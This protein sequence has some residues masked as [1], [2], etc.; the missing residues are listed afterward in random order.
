MTTLEISELT[1]LK[2]ASKRDNF[3]RF[4]KF[5]KSNSVSEETKV[6]LGDME[7]YLAADPSRVEV[8]WPGFE[9]W[10]HL[11]RHKSM[12]KT[13]ADGYKKII[14]R[15]SAPSTAPINDQ[16]VLDHFTDLHYSAKILDVVHSVIENGKGSLN[17]VDKIMAEYMLEKGNADRGRAKYLKSSFGESVAAVYRPD[18]LEWPIAAL[19]KGVGPINPGDFIILAARPECFSD[20]TE[21]LTVDG[22]VAGADLSVSHQVACV[23]DYGFSHFLHPFSVKQLP[24]DEELWHFYNDKGSVDLLVTADHRMTHRV[25]GAATLKETLASEMKWNYNKDYVVAAP[26]PAGEVELTPYERVQIAFQADGSYGNPAST[27]VRAGGISYKFSLKKAR[28][29]ERLKMLCDMAGIRYTTSAAKRGQTYFHVVANGLSKEFDWVNLE[30]MSQAKAKQFIDEVA[31]W[32]STRRSETRIKFDTTNKAVADKVQAVAVL[33]GYR[34]Y[35]SR[36]EDNRKETFND[37][38]SLTILCDKDFVSGGTIKSKLV[39]YKGNVTA[40]QVPTGRVLVRRNGKVA[41]SGNCGKTSLALFFAQHWLKQTTGNLLIVNN[42]ERGAKIK[43]RFAQ[44]TLAMMRTDLE[45]MKPEEVDDAMNTAIGSTDRVVLLESD[46]VSVSDVER[47][48]AEIQPKFIIFNVLDKVT[49]FEEAKGNDVARLRRLFQWGRALAARGI[50]VVALAQAGEEA[51]GVQWITQN[52]IYGS[53]TGA[54]GEAD[55]MLTMG[56]KNE[57]GSASKRFI[58]TPKN[59]LPGG[60]GSDPRER[61]GYHIVEFDQETGQFDG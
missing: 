39:P 46:Y 7:T 50:V 44:C 6:L 61:H 47:A 40:A 52:M 56:K 45:E 32:D 34:C 59:K 8:D 14:E 15:L 53:K 13:K 22:W 17:D 33:A 28:K 16:A 31:N 29:I 25:K 5:I 24:V 3:D 51:E 30:D 37:I 42:E 20:D 18:G 23:D 21:F 11:V 41:V 38:Y 4:K 58:H 43:A 49:G 27:G 12:A 1:L 26:K 2:A 19:N 60:K 55:L 48:V 35:M 36:T 9:A 54:A 57:A 10:F